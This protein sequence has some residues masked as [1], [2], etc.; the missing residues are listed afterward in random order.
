MAWH[1][2]SVKPLSEAMMVKLLT[3]LCVTRPQWVKQL[4]NLVGYTIM[5]LWYVIYSLKC[6]KNLC[7]IVVNSYDSYFGVSTYISSLIEMRM[8]QKLCPVVLLLL[9]VKYWVLPESYQFLLLMLGSVYLQTRNSNKKN[10]VIISCGII[11]FW[12]SLHQLMTFA[13]L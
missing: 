5:S 12:T 6:L 4:S 10:P 8:Q 7:R 9:C 1:R 11:W 2:P 13:T 3:D